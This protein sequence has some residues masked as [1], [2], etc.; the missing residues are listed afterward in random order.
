MFALPEIQNNLDRNGVPFSEEIKH[1]LEKNLKAC[2]DQ[3]YWTATAYKEHRTSSQETAIVKVMPKLRVVIFLSSAR[4][5]RLADRVLKFVKPRVESNFDV[6]I[7]GNL[8]LL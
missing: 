4:D 2:L 6:K 7:H 1:R 8:S 3:F 5:G